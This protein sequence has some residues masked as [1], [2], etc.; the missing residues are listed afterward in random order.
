MMLSMLAVRLAGSKEARR[1]PGA[2]PRNSD[3]GG[4]Q[5]WA[6]SNSVTLSTSRWGLKGLVM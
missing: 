5:L 6:P 2:A 3:S 4:D 1:R